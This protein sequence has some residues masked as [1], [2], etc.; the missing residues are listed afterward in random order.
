MGCGASFKAFQP[1]GFINIKDELPKWCKR[2]KGSKGSKASKG[3][4]RRSVQIVLPNEII[5]GTDQ[6]DLDA[7]DDLMEHSNSWSPTPRSSGLGMLGVPMPPN[8]RTHEKHLQ[9]MNRFLND[10]DSGGLYVMVDLKRELH[11]LRAEL[12]EPEAKKVSDNS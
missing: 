10:L 6:V 12:D 2:S 1:G 9:K 5:D 11:G 7:M 4:A 3:R 8:R